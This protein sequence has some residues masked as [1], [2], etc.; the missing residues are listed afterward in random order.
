MHTYFISVIYQNRMPERTLAIRTEVYS[1]VLNKKKFQ[2]GGWRD[3][4][5]CNENYGKF[6]VYSCYEGVKTK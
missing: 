6:H 5:G 3:K 1:I 4:D 2:T